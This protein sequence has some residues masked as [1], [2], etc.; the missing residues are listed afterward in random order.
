[1][2]LLKKTLLIAVLACVPASSA[3]ATNP[4]PV[5]QYAEVQTHIVNGTWTSLSEQESSRALYVFHLRS[6][7]Y[8]MAFLKAEQEAL[9]NTG[10]DI[11]VFPFP[12]T[13]ARVD[14]IAYL[15]FA[16]DKDLLE[17]YDKNQPINA[18]DSQSSQAYI[19][20]FNANLNA[21]LFAKK[22]LDEQGEF[23]GTPLFIYQNTKGEWNAFA[24][25]SK[26][27]FAPVKAELLQS[28]SGN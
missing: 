24:G 12:S 16:R 3:F 13:R 18:P 5:S 11:R 6:C 7:P 19:D 14:D 21:Y 25:Y 27:H 15:A 26:E 9:I 20:A 1:M 28:L 2:S 23:A 4:I 17:K 10:V 22:L 8:C